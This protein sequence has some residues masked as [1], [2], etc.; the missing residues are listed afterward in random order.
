MLTDE[1]AAELTM[2][3]RVANHLQSNLSIIQDNTE[4]MDVLTQLKTAL[5]EI[6]AQLSDE[7]QD[8]ML[9]QYKT[10]AEMLGLLNKDKA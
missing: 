7:E 3:M 4:T 1:Q 6:F 10:E 2:M 9:E 5:S 8:R